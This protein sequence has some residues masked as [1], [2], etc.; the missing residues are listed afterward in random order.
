MKFLALAVQKLYPEQTGRNT[1]RQTDRQT[2]TQTHRQTDPT[3][4]ITYP[5]ARL[6]IIQILI[7]QI[8]SPRLNLQE[9]SNE[10]SEV[11]GRR[12]NSK[13]YEQV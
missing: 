6:V 4:I 12:Q 9:E 5:H 11:Y 7:N 13:S 2:E 1:D 10:K 3:E 8:E